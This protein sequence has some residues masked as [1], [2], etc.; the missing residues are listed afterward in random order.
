[1]KTI[2]VITSSRSDFSIYLP[3]LRHIEKDSAL[4]L[5]LLV[6][7]MHLESR[8]GNTIEA[9]E[10]A[11]FTIKV[12]LPTLSGS[13]DPAGI[14]HSISNGIA[15]FAD[16][17]STWRPDILVA[18]GDRYEMYA[19]VVASLPFGIPVAHIH[20]GE[21]TQGAIDEP[22]RHSITK[23]SHIH[24]VT[25]ETYRRRVIQLGEDPSSVHHVGAPALDNLDGFTA[26]SLVELND[27][28]GTPLD[29]EFALVTFHPVTLE[30]ERTH[31]HVRAMLDAIVRSGLY[32]VFTLPNADTHGRM[33]IDA[34]TG[35]VSE[36]PDS[37]CVVENFGLDGYFSAMS[38]AKVMIGNSSS[39]IIEAASFALPVVN[40]GIRQQ[41][42]VRGE[43]VIDVPPSTKDITGAI[44][45]ATSPEFVE[46]CNAT[47]NPYKKGNA[48]EQ[49]VAI[50]RN[51]STDSL[52]I[53]QFHDL[54][55]GDL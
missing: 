51:V 21:T 48:A 3:V 1:M 9:V 29:R 38:H 30:H 50:L 34:I 52:V 53:K 23:M 15:R 44:K 2:G 12:R 45:R 26:L 5:Q 4:D 35:F 13:D 24:F 43:N 18:L 39:G 41:G 6:T 28:Y 14:A 55:T 10:D 17:Y 11:G 8:F 27:A 25:T 32:A 42:R 7:G 49:I 19:A 54:P 46:K 31:D 40:I 16:L 37:A 20:G 36:H 47:K 33:V 22:I